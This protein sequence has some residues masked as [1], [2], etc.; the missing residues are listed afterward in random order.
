VEPCSTDPGQPIADPDDVLIG[1]LAA[2]ASVLD[3][4]PAAVL[5]N[6]C[7]AYAEAFG[8][9]KGARFANFAE[10]WCGRE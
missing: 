9:V 5:Q 8:E 1:R 2:I 10:D 7:R 4:M 6:A 3:P